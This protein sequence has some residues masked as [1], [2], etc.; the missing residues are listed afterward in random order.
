M[1][2]QIMTTFAVAPQI[3]V[4]GLSRGY[5]VEN[6]SAPSAP[7]H[8][9]HVPSSEE[10]VTRSPSAKGRSA[11]S[12][13]WL[14]ASRRRRRQ[15]HREASSGGR[16]RSRLGRRGRAARERNRNGAFHCE[17]LR[18]WRRRVCE[19]LGLTLLLNVLDVAASEK[20]SEQMS[21]GGRGKSCQ[22][23]GAYSCSVTLNSKASGRSRKPMPR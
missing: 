4:P 10:D 16:L 6:S 21:E 7:Q 1:T 22:K 14:A 15:R 17:I 20:L 3:I 12:A 11:A 8:T 5:G 9:R 23:A 2:I 18:R 13:A 19:R